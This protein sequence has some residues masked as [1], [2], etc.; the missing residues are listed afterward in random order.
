MQS[1]PLGDPV[2]SSAKLSA[3]SLCTHLTVQAEASPHIT[4]W[5]PTMHAAIP[6]VLPNTHPWHT[7]GGGAGSG[8]PKVWKYR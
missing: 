2:V 1:V 5:Q 6:V 7:G 8:G 3:T 4:V